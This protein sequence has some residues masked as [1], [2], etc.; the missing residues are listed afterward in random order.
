ME[1]KPPPLDA[2]GCQG[3]R[4]GERGSVEAELHSRRPRAGSPRGQGARLFDRFTDR[5]KKTLNLAR[6]EAQRLKHEYLGTEHILLGLAAIEGG[7]AF[8]VLKQRGIDGRRIRA[9]IEKIVKPGSSMVDT[10]S[11]LPFTPRAKKVLELSMEEASRFG[12]NYIGT[13]HL[14][15]GLIAEDQGVGAAVLHTLGVHLDDLR[16]NVLEFLDFG[17]EDDLPG[18]PNAGHATTSRSLA[19]APFRDRQLLSCCI[20]TEPRTDALVDRDAELELLASVL[21]RASDSSAMLVGPAGSGKSAILHAFARRAKSRTLP[22]GL[23]GARCVSVSWSG[24]LLGSI[25]PAAFAER[26][27]K[28]WSAAQDAPDVVLVFDPLPMLAR[29]PSDPRPEEIDALHAFLEVLC[30]GD[31]PC[32]ATALPEAWTAFCRSDPALARRFTP[33]HVAPMSPAQSLAVLHTAKERFERHHR[34]L[35][36]PA[37]L[38]LAVELSETAFPGRARPGRALDLLDQTAALGVTRADPPPPEEETL[39][40]QIEQLQ[41]EKDQC[42]YKQDFPR[43][44]AARDAAAEKLRELE[45]RTRRR[46]EARRPIALDTADVR[47]CAERLAPPG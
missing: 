1:D 25:G 23:C 24:L 43:A 27:K 26:F 44:A 9:E 39:R 36:A 12:H 7:V 22:G 13:E 28:L 38:E 31:V 41:R 37:A 19:K 47:A 35:F 20:E 33:V 30:R 10:M 17:V 29:V 5:A 18:V 21:L 8:E 15:L 2:R 46:A 14:L 40:A 45:A 16:S 11:Q 3:S 32:I 34:V 6:Q 4:W 42:V